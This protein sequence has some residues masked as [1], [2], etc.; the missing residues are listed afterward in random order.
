MGQ[1]LFKSLLDKLNA[2]SVDILASLLM[3]KDGV[4]LVSASP[5]THASLEGPD[6]DK[7]SALSASILHLGH[8][9][10]DEFL[11]GEID[12]VLIRGKGGYMLAIHGQ[13]LALAVLAKPDAEAGLIFTQMEQAMDGL[14][15]LSCAP[16][17]HY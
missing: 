14:L 16:P 1:Q 5:T 17:K 3:T 13:E 15:S 6:E 9:F 11:G 7:M 10:M 12:Q 8:K 4:A 2:T